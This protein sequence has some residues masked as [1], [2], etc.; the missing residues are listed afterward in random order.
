MSIKLPCELYT[1]PLAQ[2]RVGIRCSAVCDR[3]VVRDATHALFAS[4][5][6]QSFTRPISAIFYFTFY[7]DLKTFEHEWLLVLIQSEW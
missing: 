2:I 5:S 4:N 7:Q 1:V 3:R 6:R